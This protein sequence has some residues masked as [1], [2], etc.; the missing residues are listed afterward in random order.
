MRARV[1]DE[2][3]EVVGRGGAAEEIMSVDME[4]TGGGEEG[5][6]SLLLNSLMK[7]L[8]F[9][10]MVF[11]GS[12]FAPANDELLGSVGVVERSTT[13]EEVRFFAF[14]LPLLLAE[15]SLDQLVAVWLKPVSGA[16]TDCDGAEPVSLA[17]AVALRDRSRT[18]A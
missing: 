2:G 3:V 11:D 10:A 12:P 15:R 18:C 8:F 14:A 13:D 9:L 7:P 16:R 4:G 6:F 5:I 1:I 17:V